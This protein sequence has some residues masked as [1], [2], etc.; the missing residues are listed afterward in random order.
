M[1]TYKKLKKRIE[2]ITKISGN[3]PGAIYISK[4][5]QIEMKGIS[6]IDG[7]ELILHEIKLTTTVKTDCFAYCN[8]KCKAL[9]DLFCKNE[10]CKFYKKDVENMKS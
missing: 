7:V 4:Q 8:G 3:K 1:D 6:N 10:K 2:E 9:I 5:E